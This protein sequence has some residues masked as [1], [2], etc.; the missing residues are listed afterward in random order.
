MSL[1]RA[2]ISIGLHGVTG[3]AQL[4]HYGP[5]PSVAHSLGIWSS[6]R[7]LVR[8]ESGRSVPSADEFPSRCF[9]FSGRQCTF[10]HLSSQLP[11]QEKLRLVLR[12]RD[13]PHLSTLKKAR[14][15]LLQAG[16]VLVLGGRIRRP[17]NRGSPPSGAHRL[18]HRWLPCL[19]CFSAEPMNQ[20]PVPPKVGC[21]RPT[22]RQA[23]AL[24]YQ[25]D[26]PPGS[27]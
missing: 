25:R 6:V 21:R 1:K 15:I 23:R 4:Q 7:L 12:L 3:G 14:H 11:D 19:L 27:D 16:L 22:A 13:H 18:L 20:T 5:T 9:V 24:R 17:W 2:R 26:V 8:L 10:S